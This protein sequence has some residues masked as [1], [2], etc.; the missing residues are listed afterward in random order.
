MN[1]M[2]PMGTGPKAFHATRGCE[3]A[4]ILADIKVL[5]L[6]DDGG[7]FAQG[8]DIDYS[9]QGDSI[10]EVKQR[11][12]HGLQ[13]TLEANLDAYGEIYRV[14]K[15]APQEYWDTYW[16]QHKQWF[17]TMGV[18]HSVEA[19]APTRQPFTFNINYAQRAEPVA[20]GI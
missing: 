20:A 2:N 16:K 8:L 6:N 1:P 15:V 4:V 9:A 10:E 14:L 18:I 17:I 11:F 3:H 13:R 12:E 7:W 19:P 5:I